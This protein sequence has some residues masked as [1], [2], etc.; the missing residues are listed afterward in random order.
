MM[1]GIIYQKVIH[2]EGRRN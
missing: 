1:K 2:E